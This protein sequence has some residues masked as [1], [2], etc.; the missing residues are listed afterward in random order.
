M[1]NEQ[2]LYPTRIPRRTGKT[3]RQLLRTLIL[4]S[5]GHNVLYSCY[6]R[7]HAD[8]LWSTASDIVRAIITDVTYDGKSHT[9]KFPEKGGLIKFVSKVDEHDVKSLRAKVIAEDTM[10]NRVGVIK[11]S[12]NWIKMSSSDERTALFSKF[13]PYNVLLS[14]EVGV[15][16]YY[17]FCDEF[18][19]VT[20]CE[21]CPEYV[22]EFNT[23][24]SLLTVAFSKVCVNI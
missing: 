3:F 20:P 2:L 9:I 14:P 11:V 24:E 13:H 17:G 18:D 12:S 21:K 6:N 7:G 23:S 8:N 10:N 4:A 16:E 5:E 19:E 22:A 1:T 15:L